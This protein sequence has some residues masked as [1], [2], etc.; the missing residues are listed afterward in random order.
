[1]AKEKIL[2]VYIGLRRPP[3][4]FVIHRWLGPGHEVFEAYK[5]ETLH[6]FVSKLLTVLSSTRQDLMQ[7]VERLDDEDFQHSKLK[8]RRYIAEHRDVLYINSSHLTERY[9][10]QVL[11]YWV[12]T[13]I[14]SKEVSTIIGYA[15]QAAGVKR[16]SISKLQL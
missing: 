6:G 5:P 8:T 3:R 13:N 14:G 12:A 4:R 16:E 2:G 1:M 7:T 15:C 9:S 11:G 10:E